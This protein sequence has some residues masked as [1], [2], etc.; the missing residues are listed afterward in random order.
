MKKGRLDAGAGAKVHQEAAK[1]RVCSEDWNDELVEHLTEVYGADAGKWG[2]DKK[3]FTR[4]QESGFW[5]KWET[6]GHT[7]TQ[8]RGAID[9]VK[10]GRLKE[11]VPAAKEKAGTK[12]AKATVAKG[13][14][15]RAKA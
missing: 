8:L 4:V 7:E 9:R 5:K 14:A 6:A 13:S 12:R 10:K 11:G 1:S 2:A 3:I 15:K